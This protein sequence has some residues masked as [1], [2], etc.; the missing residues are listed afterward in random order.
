MMAMDK[1]TIL[2]L[3][4]S[5]KTTLA[6]KMSQKLGIPVTHL[7]KIFWREKGGIKQDIFVDDLQEVM[8]ADRWI[9]EGSMPRSKTLPMRLENAD[10]IILYDMPLWH[11]LWR[12]TKRFFKYYGKVRPD[13]GGDYVQKYPFTWSELM[14][15]LKY[16]ME[17]LYSKIEPYKT[18]KKV[19]VIKSKK[20]ETEF[21]KSLA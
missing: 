7:D 18:S 13:M 10:T 11:V 6:H 2:G 12:Q 3:T 17:D 21:V 1:I 9:I 5:G 15:A 8:K 16:P 19:I 20:D 4:A 14:H